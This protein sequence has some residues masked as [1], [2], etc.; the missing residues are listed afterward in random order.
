M[1]TLERACV[2]GKKGPD[3]E[4][5][6]VAE[7]RIDVW[8]GVEHVQHELAAHHG[9]R[10]L[11]VVL[12]GAAA[13]I[14]VVIAHQADEAGI[15]NIGLL[16]GAPVAFKALLGAGVHPA[17][18][19][20]N[21]PIPSL[22]EMARHVQAGG[23][24]RESDDLLDRVGGEVHDLDDGAAGAFQH[25]SARGCLLDAGDDD[26][27]R[28]MP[29]DGTDVVFLTLGVVARVGDVDAE[30]AVLDAVINAAQHVRKDVLR[31]RWHKHRHDI[32]AARGKG[33]GVEIGDIV[34]VGDRLLDDAPQIG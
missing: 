11:M 19:E 25:L 22:D 24:M 7:H 26:G 27:R 23:L 31:Q 30:A 6:V 5:V 3:R 15:E 32:G 9:G 4:H 20:G 10:K 13:R 8:P 14:L 28:P 17:G 33:A 2:A 1:R 34:E 12:P 21:A 29:E 18:K 16:E